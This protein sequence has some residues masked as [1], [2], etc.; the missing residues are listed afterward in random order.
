MDTGACSANCKMSCSN[1]VSCRVLRVTPRPLAKLAPSNMPL[2]P[3]PSLV[4]TFVR[5]VDLGSKR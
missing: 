3:P 4:K 5:V 1:C 2:T